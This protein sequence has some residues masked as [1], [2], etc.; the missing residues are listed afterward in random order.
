MGTVIQG[1]ANWQET[2]SIREPAVEVSEVTSVPPAYG[3]YK[4]TRRIVDRDIR[5]TPN[6]QTDGVD[7]Y[8]RMQVIATLRKW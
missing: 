7:W 2:P 6:F 4:G 1:A 8:P 3:I 5:F